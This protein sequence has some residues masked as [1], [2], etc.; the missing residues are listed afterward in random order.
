[1]A[2]NTGLER[3]ED[4]GR[5]RSADAYRD[6][7]DLDLYREAF[8]GVG[9][10]EKFA[11]SDIDGIFGAFVRHTGHGLWERRGFVLIQEHK[12]RDPDGLDEHSGQLRALRALRGATAYLGRFPR[13]TVLVTFGDTKDPRA[14]RYR[15]LR[16]EGLTAPSLPFTDDIEQ[17]P[18]RIWIQA[19]LSRSR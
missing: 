19:V 10:S 14:Q 8:V 6:Q 3:P 9:L 15:W 16:P 17:W 7:P 1:M 4:V 18:H 11:G 5:I 12:R 2:P 13:I